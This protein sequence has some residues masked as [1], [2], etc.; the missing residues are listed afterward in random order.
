MTFRLQCAVVLTVTC[1]ILA[2]VVRA[3]QDALAEAQHEYNTGQYH[4][5]VDTLTAA[6]ANSP[7]DPALHFLLG[8]TYFQLHEYPRASAS[9]ERSVQLLPGNSQYHNW[10][11]KAYGRRAEESIFF[12]ALSW[13]RK[14]HREFEVAVELDPANFEAQRDLIRFEMLAPSI[15]GGGDDKAQKHIDDLEKI[16]VVQGLLA[17][18]EF[19]AV[20]KKFPESDAVFAKLL[21]SGSA[22]IGVY[23]EVADYYRDRQNEAKMGEAVAAAGRID[24]DDRRMKYYRGVHLVMAGKKPDEAENLLRSYYK[25][26]PDNADLPPHASALEW[27]GKLRES[28]GRFSEA[29]ED[30]RLSLTL[31]PHNKTVE[32]A[33]KRVKEK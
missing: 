25:T 13:A 6:I 4:H 11:G 23:F 8:Q 20:K 5:A 29:A 30:Y 31:D 10:L 17:R 27:L 24:P 12:N 18:G 7:D 2:P 33:Y 16:D 28:Q 3:A 15:V 14:T 32:E 9:F 1:M 22:H 26:V 19:F 21:E